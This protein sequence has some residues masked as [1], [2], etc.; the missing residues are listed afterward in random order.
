MG[1]TGHG[2]FIVMPEE[3]SLGSTYLLLPRHASFI[4]TGALGP[5]VIRKR[6]QIPIIVSGFPLFVSVAGCYLFAFRSDLE[7]TYFLR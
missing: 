4:C 7:S 3:E 2:L 5:D 6:L 1:K